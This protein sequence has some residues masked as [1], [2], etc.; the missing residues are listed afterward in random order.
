MK[1]FAKEQ[2]SDVIII[3]AGVVGCAIARELS[4]YQLDVLLLE[5]END[6][7]MGASKA[8]SGIV[9]GGY[10]AKHGTQKGYFSRKGNRMF[11]QLNDELNFGYLECGSLVVA[12][13]EEELDILHH[14][15]E[16]GIKNGVDDLEIIE[17]EQILALEPHLNPKVKYALY[18]KSAGIAS[19]YEMTIALAENAI[20]NG[21]SL[22]L[23]S[24]V[25]NISKGLVSEFV[26]TED[27][28]IE[29]DE[30]VFEVTTM[31][32]GQKTA[33]YGRYIVNAAGVYSDMIPQM[34][35]MNEFSIN[36][37]KGEYILMNKNQGHL[38]K[39]VIFQ[40]PTAK[41]K[42][43]LVT[44]TYH[45]NLM[46]GPNAS[47]VQDRTEVGTDI[48]V[49]S[50][51]VKTARKSVKD[52]D[53]KY[54]LTSF[55]GLRASSSIKDF[56][57]EESKVKR[58]INVAGIES[59]GLTSSPAIAVYVTELLKTS[60]LEL[61]EDKNFH[62]NRKSIIIEKD[63]NFEGKVDHEEA[64]MNIIC[65][66][67]KVTESEIIDAMNRG[68]PIDH[69]DGIKRRSRA[70]MGACQGNF[71]TSRITALIARELGIDESEVTTRGKGSLSLPSREDRTFWKR[72]EE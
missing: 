48:D 55:A 67:E 12:F 71:C 63:E 56:I 44:R 28:G 40:T 36:P 72:L 22:Q 13:D 68:I 24:E 47:E 37:R 21:V 45:G 7:S 61:I 59:P 60:G 20:T 23:K 3:G 34:L 18:C 43:I 41:G 9:H 8:N 33:Y 51:I 6:V 52:F 25:V 30:D 32:D 1:F 15:M 26:N 14:L 5:K 10:D 19:P 64:D 31:K 62:P 54:T 39:G 4:K 53:T 50:Y 69:V 58:F 70:T 2:V 57:I 17:R 16:N 42:G 29:E 27:T 46:L 49:L 11:K 38:A 35:G 66:C 65:R